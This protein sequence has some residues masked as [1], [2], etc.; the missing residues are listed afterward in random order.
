MLLRLRRD[1]WRADG[2]LIMF[3]FADPQ[4]MIVRTPSGDF[5][6]E[7]FRVAHADDPNG[8]PE[9]APYALP[10]RSLESWQIELNEAADRRAD[11]LRVLVTGTNSQ[12]QLEVYRNKYERAL[13]GDLSFLEAEATARGISAAQLAA[14]II[15]KA[16]AWRDAGQAIEA[17]RGAHKM[18][19]AALPNAAAAQAYDIEAGWPA[20]P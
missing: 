8:V 15:A 16:E 12:T 14:V 18:A 9:I 13:A 6:L 7:Q 1:H 11:A 17:A 3:I 19:I 4:H 20:L 10:E 5:R 2:V